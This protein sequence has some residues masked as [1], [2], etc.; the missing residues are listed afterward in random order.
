LCKEEP[1]LLPLRDH[2][3]TRR[4]PVVTVTL[5]AI[6]VLVFLVE[7]T[8]DLGGNLNAFL[9]RW[10]V[11]PYDV[12]R[13][14]NLEEILTFFSAMFLHGGV[15]HIAGNMLYLWI[16]GNNVEDEMG[17]GRFVIFYLLC[18]ILAS[19]A[20]VLVG[21]SVEIPSIGAS[22]AIAGVLGGYL[23]LF[24]RARV[25]TL[26]IFGIFG[27]VRDLPAIWVLGFWFALQLFN[28]F[29]SMG[30]FQSGG[31]AWFA[32][33]GGFVAGLVLVKLFARGRPSPPRPI[34]RAPRDW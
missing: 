16:F 9:E 34:Y 4:F 32:H 22:G 14:L 27:R 30:S 2:I 8:L 29:L 33:I 19:L 31:V 11:I 21:P 1:A 3:P 25:S 24:P 23:L 13:N 5:I 20:Q 10:G 6:N 28:G 15:M 18:G 12:T 26:I 7:V 17:R